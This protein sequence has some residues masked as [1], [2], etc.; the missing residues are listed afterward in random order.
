MFPPN[1]SST[2]EKPSTINAMNPEFANVKSNDTESGIV[3]THS[4]RKSDVTAAE[5]V[6]KVRHPRDMFSS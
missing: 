2:S 4:E 3:Y 6:L 1:S 5:Q